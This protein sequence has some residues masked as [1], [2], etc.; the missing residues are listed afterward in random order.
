MTGHGVS[1]DASCTPVSIAARDSGDDVIQVLE[2]RSTRG[3]I[4]GVT[5]CCPIASDAHVGKTMP[6]RVCQ[7]CVSYCGSR[8]LALMGSCS[9]KCALSGGSVGLG[10]TTA[11]LL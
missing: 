4:T 11:E 8:G 1:N 10:R 9:E 2:V 5:D 6:A 7:R 3:D